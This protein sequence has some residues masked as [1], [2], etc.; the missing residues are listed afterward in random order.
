MI[1]E[2]NSG[3]DDTGNTNSVYEIQIGR[4]DDTENTNG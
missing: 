2:N 1:L 4:Y 3:Y